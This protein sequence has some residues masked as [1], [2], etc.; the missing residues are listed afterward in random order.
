MTNPQYPDREILYATEQEMRGFA[1]ATHAEKRKGVSP[2]LLEKY[3]GLTTKR[4]REPFVPPTNSIEN[5]QTQSY[6][7]IL[8]Q[9][10]ACCDTGE[11][12]LIFS[13]TLSF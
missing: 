9:M 10:I 8:E 7:G 11:S 13:P 2:E 1:S 12:S 3:G 5:R 6:Q 4:P